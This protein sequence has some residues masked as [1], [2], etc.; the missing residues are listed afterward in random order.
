MSSWLQP[1]VHWEA[2]CA[3]P[4]A[5]SLTSEVFPTPESPTTRMRSVLVSAN[6]MVHNC[7]GSHGARLSV[8]HIHGRRLRH[9]VCVLVH[10]Q[11]TNPLAAHTTVGKHRSVLFC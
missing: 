5:S 2:G 8:A 4:V 9:L 10:S 11:S 3:L 6:D 1:T 7:H